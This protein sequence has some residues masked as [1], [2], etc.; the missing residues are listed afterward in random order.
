LSVKRWVGDFCVSASLTSL[1]TLARVDSL[2]RRVTSISSAP[3]PLI[4]P[5]KTR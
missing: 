1:I 3:L 2:A 4:V 5:A